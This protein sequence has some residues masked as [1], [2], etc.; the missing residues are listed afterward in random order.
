MTVNVIFPINGKTVYWQTS[1]N[2]FL[3]NSSLEFPDKLKIKVP[4]LKW[5]K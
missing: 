2:L 5:K 1:I 4:L 3:D